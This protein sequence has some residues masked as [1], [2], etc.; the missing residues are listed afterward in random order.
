MRCSSC[1]SSSVSS[2]SAATGGHIDWLP[3]RYY[4]LTPLTHAA[5]AD[6]RSCSFIYYEHHIYNTSICSSSSLTYRKKKKYLWKHKRSSI[7]NSFF[8]C[9]T[10]CVEHQS[11]RV[12]PLLRNLENTWNL[13]DDDDDLSLCIM[14]AP[15]IRNRKKERRD[16]SME[17]NDRSAHQNWCGMGRHQRATSSYKKLYYHPFASKAVV[18]TASRRYMVYYHMHQWLA[19]HWYN[20]SY[21][22]PRIKELTIFAFTSEELY[23]SRIGNKATLFSLSHLRLDKSN[24]FARCFTH[25]YAPE[26]SKREKSKIKIGFFLIVSL[27]IYNSIFSCVPNSIWWKRAEHFLF[28]FFLHT[29]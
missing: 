1:A 17:N 24:L 7:E 27:S 5:R 20:M 11:T 3:A 15:G 16:S 26:F 4:A 19:E 2:G 14:L 29:S 6:P 22:R 9:S 21:T 18:L 23:L 10:R 13:W 25:G 12:L 8:V 28:F